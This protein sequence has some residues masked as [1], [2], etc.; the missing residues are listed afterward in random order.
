MGFYQFCISPLF[1]NFYWDVGNVLQYRINE[2][3]CPTVVLDT[4]N[5]P[6]CINGVLD[7]LNWFTVSLKACSDIL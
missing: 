7:L 1:K 5:S 2:K 3:G 4:L 6:D